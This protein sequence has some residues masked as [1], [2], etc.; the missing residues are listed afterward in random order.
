MLKGSIIKDGEDAFWYRNHQSTP[1]VY[2]RK[3]IK[4]MKKRGLWVCP[5]HQFYM[6]HQYVSSRH[7]PHSII[8][9][10][11][12]INPKTHSVHTMHTF[13]LFSDK[14]KLKKAY[15]TFVSTSVKACIL[16]VDI[17]TKRNKP[18]PN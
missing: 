5:F 3:F 11:Y 9:H 7:D 17:D 6:G 10:C 12:F 1:N 4:V 16:R 18:C 15:N 14:K 13:H 2:G 8:L